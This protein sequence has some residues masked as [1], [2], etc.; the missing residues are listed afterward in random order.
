MNNENA[1]TEFVA[2]TSQKIADNLAHEVFLI[3][4]FVDGCDFDAKLGEMLVFVNSIP[5]TSKNEMLASIQNFDVSFDTFKTT[6]SV[7]AESVN[8][9]ARIVDILEHDLKYHTDKIILSNIKMLLRIA[10]QYRNTSDLTPKDLFSEGMLGLRR[11]IELF[12]PN[13]G[14][15]FSTYATQWVKATINR[16]ISDKDSLIRIPVNVREQTKEVERIKKS[17]TLELGREPNEVEIISQMKKKV[18]SLSNLDTSFIYYKL[19]TNPDSSFD[20]AD[21]VSFDDNLTDNKIVDGVDA[22]A[23]NDVRRIIKEYVES[24]SNEHERYYIKYHFGLN[25][26][27]VIQSREEIMQALNIKANE[28]EGIRRKAI[29]NLKKALLKNKNLV[30]AYSMVSGWHEHSNI[31]AII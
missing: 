18:S 20:M 27:S 10:S 25:D 13:T 2:Y 28:Y 9:N 30:E 7:L 23:I 8:T 31:E 3:P 15:K 29:N 26:E 14:N 1:Y 21:N 17:L 6:R 22:V 19:D 11:A 12:N 4:S 16:A 5:T 24:I